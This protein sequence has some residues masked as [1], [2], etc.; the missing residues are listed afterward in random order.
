MKR[1]FSLPAGFAG[2]VCFLAIATFSSIA[3]APSAHAQII[4][5]EVVRYIKPKQRPVE[6]ILLKNTDDKRSFEVTTDVI[7]EIGSGSP[8][9]TQEPTKDIIIAPPSFII[10]PGETKLTRMV[11]SKPADPNEER[12]YRVHFRPGKGRTPDAD[13]K[14]DPQGGVKTQITFVTTTGMLILVAPQNMDP[15]LTYTRDKDAITF[16]NDGNVTLDI[17]RFDNYCFDQEQK[18]CMDLPGYRL[19]PGQSWRLEIPGN[20]PVRYNYSAYEDIRS[21]TVDAQN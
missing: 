4:V 10:K 6:N 15:K 21:I 5:Q 11:L 19:Y 12:I 13:A 16:K 1:E 3:L 8:D 17:R 14:P 20:K 18:D 7:R 9:R 2:R